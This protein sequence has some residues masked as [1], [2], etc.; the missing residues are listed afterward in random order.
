M[1]AADRLGAGLLDLLD[2]DER[3]PCGWPDTGHQWLSE[4]Y[5]QRAR[6][7]AE[8]DGCTL[9]HVCA[10]TAAELEVSFG[11]WAGRDLTKPRRKATR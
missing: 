6:A 10:E 7:A 5:R 9:L 4:D 2:A 1:S 3:P 11:V 8:C